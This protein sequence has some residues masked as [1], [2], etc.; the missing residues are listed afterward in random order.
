MEEKQTHELGYDWV[1]WEHRNDCNNYEDN[2]SKVCEFN[3]VEDFWKYWIY[4]PKPLAFFYTNKN[5]RL[6][7][8]KSCKVYSFLIIM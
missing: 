2:L 6:C 4:L 7:L 5:N 1:I 3:T 8:K